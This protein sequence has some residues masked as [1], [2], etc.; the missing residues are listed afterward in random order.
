MIHYSVFAQPRPNQNEP[1]E[2]MSYRQNKRRTKVP[3]CSPHTELRRSTPVLFGCCI[4]FLFKKHNAL[5][6]HRWL[7]RFMKKN[8][9][10]LLMSSRH[11]QVNSKAGGPTCCGTPPLTLL[12]TEIFEKHMGHTAVLFWRTTLG[13]E[14][15]KEICLM[16]RN[17]EPQALGIFPG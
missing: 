6:S 11:T 12:L 14:S 8:H 2:C 3:V 15:F 7:F 16:L 5:S 13:E 10:L 9:D 17:T 1:C 4:N